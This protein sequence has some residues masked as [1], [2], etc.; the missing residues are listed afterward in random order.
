MIDLYTSA[1]PNGWKATKVL[2]ELAL[3][4]TLHAVNLS[5]GEQHRSEFLS[6]LTVTKRIFRPRVQRHSGLTG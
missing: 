3:Q 2:E 1:M 4:Y 6:L 5:D